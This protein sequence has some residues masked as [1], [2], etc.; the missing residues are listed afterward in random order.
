MSNDSTHINTNP[1]DFGF[2]ISPVKTN[3][4][5]ELAY[6]KL[7]RHISVARSRLQD[8]NATYK[9]TRDDSLREQISEAYEFIELFEKTMTTVQVTTGDPVATTNQPVTADDFR[10]MFP[11]HTRLLSD[12]NTNQDT[13]D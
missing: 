10:R 11:C 6:S 5:F 7:A 3:M 13:N 4:S 9:A 8:D 12:S 2:T 1:S